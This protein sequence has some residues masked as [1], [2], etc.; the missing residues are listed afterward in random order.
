LV[1]RLCV[2]KTVDY[3]SKFLSLARDM[4]TKILVRKDL[5]LSTYFWDMKIE[6]NALAIYKK[7]S[8]V[9][10]T[11]HTSWTQWKNLFSFEVFGSEG[12]LA[13]EGLGGSY[14]TE[15]LKLG[16]RKDE[17]GPPSEQT[18]EFQ[19]PDTSWE[20]EWREFILAVENNKEPIGNGWDG[21]QAN[22]MIEAIYRSS[23]AGHVIKL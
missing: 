4:W 11:M 5:S 3:N 17:S 1:F 13:I 19:G 23:E 14:G 15:R 20:E 7:S 2:G 16:R 9:I 21:Y 12:Y 18:F 10:A 6:D 22:R 8:G